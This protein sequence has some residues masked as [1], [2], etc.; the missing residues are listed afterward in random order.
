MTGPIINLP[1]MQDPPSQ[2]T[3]DRIMVIIIVLG[4]L[5]GQ[6]IAAKIF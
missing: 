1:H 5:I 3:L 4:V 6:L 2:P